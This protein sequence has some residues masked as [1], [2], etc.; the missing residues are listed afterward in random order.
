MKIGP[1]ERLTKAK[2]TLKE[3][4]KRVREETDS[5]DDLLRKV[6]GKLCDDAFFN[7]PKEAN[8]PSGGNGQG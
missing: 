8:N 1:L 6:N 5:L 2:K 4:K 7:N 3:K